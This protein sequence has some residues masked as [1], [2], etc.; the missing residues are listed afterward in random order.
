MGSRC[1]RGGYTPPSTRAIAAAR[2]PWRPLERRPRVVTLPRKKRTEPLAYL[3]KQLGVEQLVLCGQVTEQCVLCS[4][5][6]A[7]IRHFDVIVPDDAVA[8]IDRALA[9]AALTMMQR[10]MAA[11]VCDADD[12][13]L[14]APPRRLDSPR[15][16]MNRLPVF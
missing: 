3:L 13:T 10:N 8:H 6:D 11:T 16:S 2:H 12:I 15:G 9:D 1:V 5:L 7:R 14:A 4:A